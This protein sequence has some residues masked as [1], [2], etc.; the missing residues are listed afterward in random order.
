M[1]LA[2]IELTAPDITAVSYPKSS[3]PSVA[4][5]VSP[6]MSDL[7]FSVM[8][9]LPSDH[10]VPG[11]GISRSPRIYNLV[12]SVYGSAI[13]PQVPCIRAM[14]SRLGHLRHGGSASQ[15]RAE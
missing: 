3:P 2:S 15:S 10:E 5:N 11:G 14:L 8:I 13:F 12:S 7:L 9:P 6:V 4:T 1:K